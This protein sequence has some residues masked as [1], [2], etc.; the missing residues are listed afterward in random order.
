MYQ[1][2]NFVRP[3]LYQ[4]QNEDANSVY[5]TVLLGWSLINTS[6]KTW[7][8][9][10]VKLIL[11]IIIMLI[12]LLLQK[13]CFFESEWVHPN[14]LCIPGACSGAWHTRWSIYACGTNGT[15]SWARRGFR[16]QSSQSHGGAGCAQAAFSAEHRNKRCIASLF[17]RPAG[18]L[19]ATSQKGDKKGRPRSRIIQQRSILSNQ[20]SDL[21]GWIKWPIQRAS[22]L[23]QRYF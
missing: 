11:P 22:G 13:P 7:H 18:Q 2:N 1:L 15:Q 5:A 8:T 23:W 3:Q 12:T 17:C 16:L 9:A 14:H 20:S 21:R 10:S 6:H 19:P 4:W